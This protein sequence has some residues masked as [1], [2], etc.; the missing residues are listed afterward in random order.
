MATCHMG[1]RV[2]IGL[3]DIMPGSREEDQEGASPVPQDL[4]RLK[5]R[6]PERGL[7]SPGLMLGFIHLDPL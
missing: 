5:V 6:I 2:R 1:D 3:Q 4:E 7:D